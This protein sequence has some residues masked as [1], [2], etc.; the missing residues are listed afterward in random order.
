MEI[1]FATTAVL[2]ESAASAVDP[3]PANKP[4]VDAAQ[5]VKRVADAI[6][7]LEP[8]GGRLSVRLSPPDLGT[9]QID[10]SVHDGVLSARIEV[11]H[12]SVHQALSDNLG[13]LRHALA[14]HG[15]ALDRVELHLAD[16]TPE[17]GG[18]HGRQQN[19]HEQRGQQHDS[20]SRHQRK[21]DSDTDES[22]A[23][24]PD[25]LDRSEIHELDIDV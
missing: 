25:D 14:Q 15:I 1:G 24:R 10:V 19:E 23:D 21:P 13:Q 22:P 3:A 20:P 17:D 7:Q 2:P 11:D 9:L 18:R 12:A 4:E 16:R 5:F 6:R 8:N